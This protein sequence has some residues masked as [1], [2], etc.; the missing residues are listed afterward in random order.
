MQ[1]GCGL[2]QCAREL[3]MSQSDSSESL[4]LPE[5]DEAL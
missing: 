3:H 5:K 2:C 4:G 1:R